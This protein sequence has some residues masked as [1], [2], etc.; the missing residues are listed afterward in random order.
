VGGWM[1]E[2]LIGIIN[3]LNLHSWCV[4][5]IISIVWYFKMLV[6]VHGYMAGERNAAVRT[7]CR[8]GVLASIADSRKTCDDSSSQFI[9]THWE[10][11]DNQLKK[12]NDS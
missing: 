8:A 6:H 5:I 11:S 4:A 7:M 9:S 12:R 2:P 3:R 1:D 10:E